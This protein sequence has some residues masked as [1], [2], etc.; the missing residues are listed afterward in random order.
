MLS[1]QL[2]LIRGD[3][4]S[5]VLI[6]D[7]RE[8]QHSMQVTMTLNNERENYGISLVHLAIDRHEH[9]IL[10]SMLDTRSPIVSNGMVNNET[11]D[12]LSA[13]SRAFMNAS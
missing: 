3:R 1:Y 13:G 7:Y 12:M 8:D 10:Y 2:A 5:I 9:Q 6:K 4:C 11:L